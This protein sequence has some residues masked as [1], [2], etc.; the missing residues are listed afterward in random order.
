MP[1]HPSNSPE[2]SA[3]FSKLSIQQPLKKGIG[4]VLCLAVAVS[5]LGCDIDN[6]LPDQPTQVNIAAIHAFTHEPLDSQKFELV[7]YATDFCF[8]CGGAGQGTLAYLYTDS[9]GLIK[10]NFKNDVDTRYEVRQSIY[11]NHSPAYLARYYF[12]I[13]EG[14]TNNFAFELKPTTKV[15]VRFRHDR[16]PEF[17][18]SIISIDRTTREDNIEYEYLSVPDFSKGLFQAIDTVLVYYLMQEEEYTITATLNIEGAEGEGKQT[19]KVLKLERPDSL[20]IDF[21]F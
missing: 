7:W 9:S 11:G 3:A 10:H 19:T 13:M 2:Y 18:Q 4:V 15:K 16:T 1:N 5:Y 20:A 17:N 21:K 6:D 12:R 14:D 8:F